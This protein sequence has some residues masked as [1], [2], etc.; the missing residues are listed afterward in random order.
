MN[1]IVFSSNAYICIYNK[2]IIIKVKKKNIM[3]FNYN[4]FLSCNV[5]FF[6]VN[7]LKYKQLKINLT[8]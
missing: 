4:N 1:S 7:L 5:A 3:H 8:K 2:I 6:F